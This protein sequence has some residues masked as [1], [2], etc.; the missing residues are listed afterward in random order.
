MI[1]VWY[2]DAFSYLCCINVDHPIHKKTHNTG[3]FC[4]KKQTNQHIDVNF[5]IHTIQPIIQVVLKS[6]H[7]MSKIIKM[8][9]IW[10]KVV[11][12]GN[13][14]IL[15]KICEHLKCTN[16]FDLFWKFEDLKL[17]IYTF[18]YVH[19]RFARVRLSMICP[20]P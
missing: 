13:Q 7:H 3:H 8:R 4:D 1:C 17:C 12:P 9:A 18:G 14:T 6:Y 2:V 10:K 20:W 16:C 11:I 19:S 15:N 5:E